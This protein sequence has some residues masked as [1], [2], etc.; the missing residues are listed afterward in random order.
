[1]IDACNALSTVPVSV[2][3]LMRQF[4][5]RKLFIVIKTDGVIFQKDLSFLSLLTL[6][7][8]VYFKLSKFL[9]YLDVLEI[10][11]LKGSLKEES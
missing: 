11:P 10:L 1:M 8:S 4:N 3:L 6:P 9:S 5:H 2:L 7:K